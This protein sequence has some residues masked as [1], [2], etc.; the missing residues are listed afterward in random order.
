[1]ASIQM[2]RQLCM[3]MEFHIIANNIARFNKGSFLPLPNLN[4][5]NANRIF[6]VQQLRCIG[7]FVFYITFYH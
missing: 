5:M 4:I 7:S 2:Q 6:F 3:G 1:M